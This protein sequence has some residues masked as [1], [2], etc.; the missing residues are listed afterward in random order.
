MDISQK[1][2][3]AKVV[4]KTGKTLENWFKIIEQ[5]GEKKGHT[6][7]AKHLKE[8]HQLTSWWA[9]SITTRYEF[10]N[11]LRKLYERTGKKGFT[12]TAQKTMPYKVGF[13]YEAFTD[14][15][16]LK[17]WFSPYLKMSVK[18]G[19]EFNFDQVTKGKF[20]NI[21]P[22]SKI[23]LNLVSN[24][25]EEVSKVVI[26]FIKKDKA[27][28]TIKITQSDLTTEISINA[29]KDFWKHFLSA[30]STYLESVG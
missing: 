7:I 8:D 27:K 19:A 6:A 4:A 5:F 29:Q 22:N 3:P 10:D 9:Q 15:K 12:V 17:K 30:G 2:K 1:L 25:N 14:P 11:D 23:T 20:L 28:T 16:Q 24:K 13:V 18:D 26:E 21:I